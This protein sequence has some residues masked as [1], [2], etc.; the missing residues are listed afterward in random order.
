M[1]Q[2]NIVVWQTKVRRTMPFSLNAVSNDVW[3]SIKKYHALPRK[4]PIKI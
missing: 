4:I 1:F 2:S 3:Y